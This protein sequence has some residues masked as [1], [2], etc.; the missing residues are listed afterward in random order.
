[1]DQ[2]NI[3]SSSA[4]IFH[5][6]EQRKKHQQHHH[7]QRDSHASH[8]IDH[9]SQHEEE[10]DHNKEIN[11]YHHDPQTSHENM[12]PAPVKLT[13][14]MNHHHSH[15][16]IIILLTCALW[17][18]LLPIIVSGMLINIIFMWHA[19]SQSLNQDV[20]PCLE[21]PP[22]LIRTPFLS[23]CL[24]DLKLVWK[25]SWSL[26]SSQFSFL[27]SAKV[28]VSCDVCDQHQ[29]RGGNAK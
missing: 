17:I 13:M 8:F 16:S 27:I 5:H 18:S 10:A 29:T 15:H 9:K 1:M 6:E 7:L 2:I 3:T 22:H 26:E 19:M 23:W 21:I 24:E 12:L 4:L 11:R 20:S 25:S 14:R 28:L